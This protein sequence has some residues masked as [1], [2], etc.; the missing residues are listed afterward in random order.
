MRVLI[1]FLFGLGISA[2]VPP[3][4]PFRAPA[5]RPTDRP[6]CCV[7]LYFGK[8][9]SGEGAQARAVG[10][11]SEGTLHLGRPHIFS[12]FMTP[13]PLLRIFT[14]PPLLAVL[15]SSAFFQYP[16]PPSSADVIKVCP[17]SGKRTGLR[18]SGTYF[19]FCPVRDSDCA[20]ASFPLGLRLAS[21]S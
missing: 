8:K 4:M 16:L 19:I 20:G 11:E 5:G 13:S 7:T 18:E 2:Q 12:D 14:Q 6:S 9:V 15:T 21:C 10:I 17:P 3:A 1:L